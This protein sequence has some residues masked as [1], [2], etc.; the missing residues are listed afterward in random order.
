MPRSS[1]EWVLQHGEVPLV[2]G[3]PTSGASCFLGSALLF[4]CFPLHTCSSLLTCVLFL[5]GLLLGWSR[6]HPCLQQ[7]SLEHLRDKSPLCAAPWSTCEA[8]AAW[9]R[10]VSVPARRS[11]KREI[12]QWGHGKWGWGT[13]LVR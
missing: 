6:H 8:W 10:Q 13:G 12:Y 2:P 7:P 11:A 4:C 9:G 5:V 3:F 1:E